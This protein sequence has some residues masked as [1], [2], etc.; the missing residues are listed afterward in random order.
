MST[1]TAGRPQNHTVRG[2]LGEQTALKLLTKAG[3]KIIDRNFRSKFG[4][5]DLV[6][7]DGDTLVFVEVKTRWSR[8]FG[9]PEEA[10]NYWKIRSITKTG[11]Y[12]KLLHPNTPELLRIDVVAVEVANGRLIEARLIQNVS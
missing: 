9:L 5:I 11:E 10:V 1:V 2:K 4:E 12:Y 8:K 3:Y 7:I 6:A